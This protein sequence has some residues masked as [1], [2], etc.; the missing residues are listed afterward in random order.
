MLERVWVI[1]GRTGV[2]SVSL[3]FYV[4][5]NE[6]TISSGNS[7]PSATV[8]ALHVYITVQNDLLPV[9]TEIIVG[10]ASAS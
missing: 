4:I 7:K 2:R 6:Q 10:Y 5:L 9:G 1:F 3:D 8:K